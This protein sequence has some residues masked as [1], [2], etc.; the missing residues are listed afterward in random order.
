MK[1]SM[2]TAGEV[3]ERLSISTYSVYALARSGELPA[4]RIG[5]RRLRFDSARLEELI[6]GGRVN[7]HAEV[8]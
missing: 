5:P 6:A 1:D 4:V 8:E 7:E 3:A 2:L